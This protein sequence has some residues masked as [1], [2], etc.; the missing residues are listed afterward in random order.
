M[1][2]TKKI[3]NKKILFI[4]LNLKFSPFLP[5]FLFYFLLVNHR[6]ISKLMANRKLYIHLFYPVAG[7]YIFNFKNMKNWL[8][9]EK[10]WYDDEK[11]RKYNWEEVEKRGK[12][13]NFHC[14]L[15]KKYHFW[16]RG[17]GKNILFWENIHPC[18]VG[19]TFPFNE[20]LSS[21]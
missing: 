10:L 5:Y 20:D 1:F 3:C 11:K 4:H 7:V 15:G 6:I 8:A 19:L 16:K 12:R 9:G 14:T 2:T 13:G 17:G 18:P 21:R